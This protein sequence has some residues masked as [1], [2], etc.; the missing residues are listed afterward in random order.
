MRLLEV[1]QQRANLELEVEALRASM[2]PTPASGG[3]ETDDAAVAVDIGCASLT[4][5]F[6][7][8]RRCACGPHLHTLHSAVHMFA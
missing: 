6:A 2:L 3:A 1:K 7:A 5:C 8:M 4:C